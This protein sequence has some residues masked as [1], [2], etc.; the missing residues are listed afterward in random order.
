M[1]GRPTG[2]EQEPRDVCFIRYRKSWSLRPAIVYEAITRRE[3]R[4]VVLAQTRKVLGEREGAVT[5]QTELVR[6]LLR[7]G[8]IPTT[9]P[10]VV[11]DDILGVYVRRIRRDAR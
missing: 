5:A 1:I 2:S 8:W 7:E 9:E 6:R 11:G 4:D 10:L 3:G